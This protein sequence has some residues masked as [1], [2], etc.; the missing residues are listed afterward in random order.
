MNKYWVIG[1]LLVVAGVGI[2][3]SGFVYDIMFAGIPNQDAPQQVRDSY[4]LHSGIAETTELIGLGVASGSL[5]VAL[6]GSIRTFKNKRR[7]NA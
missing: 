1:A 7:Q 5:V 6:M 2:T 4:A 3:M